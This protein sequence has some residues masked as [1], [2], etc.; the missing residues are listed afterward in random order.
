M[1]GMEASPL[2]DGSPTSMGGNGEYV[3]EQEPLY[4]PQFK[5]APGGAVI[6]PTGTGGGCAKSGPVS[7]GHHILFLCDVH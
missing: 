5:D 6:R 1:T 2:F 3:P 7:S 4:Y